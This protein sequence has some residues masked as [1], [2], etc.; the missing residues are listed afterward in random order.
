MSTQNSRIGGL[1]QLLPADQQHLLTGYLN[2]L[3]TDLETSSAV[4]A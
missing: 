4:S 2:R 1:A 3:A